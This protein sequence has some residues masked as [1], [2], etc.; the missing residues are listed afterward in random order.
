MLFL[1]RRL[2]LWSSLI[3][4]MFIVNEK[5][6][7][8][9]SPSECTL[10][11]PLLS[12]TNFWQIMS[13]MPIPSLFIEAVRLSFPNCLNRELI[14]SGRMPFP[15]SITC[16]SSIF[17]GSL[18][19]AAIVTVPF[20]VNFRAFFTKLMRICFSLRWSPIRY[21]GNGVDATLSTKPFCRSERSYFVMFESVEHS[22][23]VDNNLLWT[24]NM[25]TMKL[26]IF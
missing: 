17:Y 18:Y 26:R 4:C 2:L 6:L 20:N 5:T 23:L 21:L 19:V 7:P 8:L 24:W 16:T 22:T 25:L 1:S 12:E 11:M 10:I 14:S 13:P 15:L 3:W 9:F